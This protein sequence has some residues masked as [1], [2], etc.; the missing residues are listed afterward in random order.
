MA[1]GS[2]VWP[3]FPVHLFRGPLD[4]ILAVDHLVA[5]GDLAGDGVP[6]LVPGAEAIPICLM[7]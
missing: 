2:A 4:Q 6:P 1:L 7:W 5:E 3:T